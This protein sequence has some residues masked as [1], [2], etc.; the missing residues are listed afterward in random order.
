MAEKK[1]SMIK[2]S[3]CRQF[4]KDKVT[5]A[6]IIIS[7]MLRLFWVFQ[8]MKCSAFTLMTLL[9]LWN[10]KFMG[11]K[12]NPLKYSILITGILLIINFLES[13]QLLHLIF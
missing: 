7:H 1:L 5:I 12:L 13:K 4:E 11:Y 3:E 8:I 9:E 10:Y 2:I 6:E